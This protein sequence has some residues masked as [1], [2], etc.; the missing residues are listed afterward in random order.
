MQSVPNLK[1]IFEQRRRLD[2][3]FL[4]RLLSLSVR[5]SLANFI[6]ISTWVFCAGTW[7]RLA[8]PFPGRSSPAKRLRETV[9]WVSRSNLLFSLGAVSIFGIN[10]LRPFQRI[11]NCRCFCW[12]SEVLI[13]YSNLLLGLSPSFEMLS[14]GASLFLSLWS[15][16]LGKLALYKVWAPG[17]KFDKLRTKLSLIFPLIFLPTIPEVLAF[18]S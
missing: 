12:E 13:S 9:R 14:T 3:I 4:D 18:S 6:Q 16:S 17:P 5:Y 1:L 2:Q 8:V 7:E 15:R 10:E 11:G